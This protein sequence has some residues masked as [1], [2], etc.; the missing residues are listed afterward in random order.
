MNTDHL[1]EYFETTDLSCRAVERRSGGLAHP[2]RLA[3]RERLVC[4]MTRI[5]GGAGEMP[6]YC[7]AGS[8]RLGSVADLLGIPALADPLASVATVRQALGDA[9]QSTQALPHGDHPTPPVEPCSMRHTIDWLAHSA[10]LC[11]VARDIFEL[12]VALRVFQPLRLAASTWGDM[13]QGDL[14][15]VLSAVL[16]L[17]PEAIAPACQPDALL[18]RSGLVVLNAYGDSTLDRLMKVPRLLAQRIPAHQ[19]H[20]ALILSNLVVPMVAPALSLHDFHYLRSDT[21]LAQCWLAGALDRAAG[22]EHDGNPAGAGRRGAHLLVSGAPGLGKTEWVRAL[23]AASQ[24]QAMELVVLQED[25]TALSGEERLSHLRLSLNMLRNTGR[26]VIVFDEA[27]DVFSGEGEHGDTHGAGSAVTMA[28][29]RASLNRLIED[30]RIPVIWIMNHPEILDAAVLR[31]FDTVIA[32]EA[33]P[34]S[35]CL[36]MLRQRFAPA[37]VAQGG[38]DPQPSRL[39]INDEELQHWAKV[40][41]LTPALID[42]LAVVAARAQAAGEPMGVQECRHWLRR[43]LPGKATSHLTRP[44]SPTNSTWDPGAVN[45]SEDLLAIAQGIGR[46]GSARLLLYGVPGT[47]KTAFAHALAQLLDKPLLEQRASDLLSAWVGETEQHISRAFD[48]ALQDNAVL[49]IDEVDSLLAHRAQAVRTWEVSQVNELLEQL[50]EF[51]GIVV[52]AT[53]RLDALDEAVLRRMDAKIRF[54]T[55]RPEQAA[56]SF[57]RLCLE[58]RLTC[59]PAQTEAAMALQGLT[60]G[61]FACVSRRLAFAPLPE[62]VGIK[63]HSPSEFQQVDALLDLLRQ[64]LRLK[65]RGRQP[66]GFQVQAS[67][68]NNP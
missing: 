56:A 45:A 13:G 66:M 17:D 35:V 27:D 68:G 6:A 32:F 57:Q 54:E 16:N 53:N 31:R 29:H 43:R 2:A 19:G 7:E 36:A 63:A 39:A 58:L 40:P 67:A 51:E 28:N 18:F 25:G 65:T 42:R 62:T 15:Q 8:P 14:I 9:L 3:Y 4:W 33:I 1:Q 5:L 23:L 60:P 59:S 30:S 20:P 10:G 22:S 48:T 55:L 38:G 11:E 49:F 37:P 26:G 46:C 12:A 50:S 64:E 24:A 61:D 41:T 47:G 21:R 34:R 44:S 52:L